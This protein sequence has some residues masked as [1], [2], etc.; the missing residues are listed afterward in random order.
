MFKAEI[1]ILI[2]DAENWNIKGV[3]QDKNDKS[4]LN[5]QGTLFYSYYKA[6]VCLWNLYLNSR[7][8]P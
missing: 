5:I 2:Q 6:L 8:I 1:D 7:V 4:V 3:C